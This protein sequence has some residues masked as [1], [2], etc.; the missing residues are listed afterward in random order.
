MIPAQ[1][2]EL[3]DPAV[4][5]QTKPALG[6][7]VHLAEEPHPVEGPLLVQPPEHLVQLLVQTEKHSAMLA[8]EEDH[9]HPAL[10]GQTKPVEQS[11]AHQVEEQLQLL[12]P[13]Q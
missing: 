2:A 3:L 11:A 12:A 10:N 1:Q 4:N 9:S 6:I 5:G 8:Q 7:K 13:E